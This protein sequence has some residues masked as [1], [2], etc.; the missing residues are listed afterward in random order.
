M[1]NLIDVRQAHQFD[2]GK[3][4]D[5]LHNTVG[6]AAIAQV[7]QFAGGQS[8]PTFLLTLTDGEKLVLRKK[9]PGKLLPSAHMIEREYQA[10]A[11]LSDS[12]VPVPSMVHLC[13]DDSVIGTAFYVMAHLDGRVFTDMALGDANTA[14][15]AAVYEQ[16]VNGLAA[17][18]NLDFAA[19]GLGQFGK[20]EQYLERQIA[21]W[22][23][24]YQAAR[25]DE[26]PDMDFLIDWLPSNLPPTQQT[27]IAHGDYRLG[28]LMFAAD[29]PRLI[30]VLDWELATLG[31]PLSDLAY[32]CIAYDLPPNLPDLP[33]LAGLDLAELGI[34]DET[35]YIASYCAKT[36][37]DQIDHW[38]FYMAFAYFRLTSIC[39]GVYAR[40]LQGNASDAK[41]LGYGE[42]AKWLA[43]MGRKRALS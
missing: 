12:E 17:L 32:N 11:A 14:F 35:Q 9:P 10:M 30:A 23:K 34:P 27:T 16:M 33:G 31:D 2:Q 1:S 5:F 37:R 7:Q 36:G 20:T 25:T 26:M 40:G 3:L 29:E 42:M 24:Q 13:Q 38:H 21:I 8:N 6:T 4:S 22:S 19:V 41:A 28:N 43:G 39:Q 18:H 15:R